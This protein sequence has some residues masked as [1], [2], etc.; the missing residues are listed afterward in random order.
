M[1]VACGFSEELNIDIYMT[2]QFYFWRDLQKFSKQKIHTFVLTPVEKGG[3]RASAH[4]Q[5][6]GPRKR[7][8]YP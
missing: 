1:E 4:C 7:G 5:I 6:H 2:Q 8:M 3:G